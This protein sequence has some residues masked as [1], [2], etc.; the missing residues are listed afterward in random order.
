MESIAAAIFLEE[1]GNASENADAKV[2]RRRLRDMCDPFQMSD[3]L[4]KKNFR[5]NKDA[6]KYVL[7]TFAE[8]TQQSTL[9]SLS[10]LNRVVAALRFFAEGSYQHGVGTD[11]NV[12]MGQSTVSKSL[13]HFLEVMQRK[14]CPEW[15][16]FDQSEE[17]KIQAKQEFYAKASFPGVIMCVDGTHIKIVKPS[18]EGFLYYNRKGFYSINAMVV[19]DNRMRIKSIDARYPG[20]NH[21]S[22]VWGLSK[23]RSHMERRYRE[24]ERN[25]WL[26]GDAGYPL[27]PW[28]MTPYRSVSQGSPQSNYNMRHSTT[29][30][31]V[32]R[33]IGVLKNRFRC[34][35]GARELHY[36]PHKVSQ[37][38]N[39]ACA[40]HNICIYY[41][42]GDLN[43]NEF[44]FESRQE[45]E[46]E[47]QSSDPDY[48]SIA[49]RIRDNILATF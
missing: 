46:E 20:C 21:D 36:S 6:F 23:L 1:D 14:L 11:Y 19:C 13:S 9:T 32:E 5:L 40:L 48:T 15:I 16:K 18:E 25:A 4:F 37:I 47:E 38:I 17:E 41:K 30:N 45:E 39:V 10:P 8:E 3:E 34:L 24:G 2:E 7:D 44:N 49:N 22:H 28:L 33:T 27:Q 12:G 43:A 42:V 35:L 29:R 31:I 26:L